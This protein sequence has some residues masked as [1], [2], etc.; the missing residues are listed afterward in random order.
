MLA[1]VGMCTVT[2]LYIA[3]A[4]APEC[5]ESLEPPIIAS[6]GL[7]PLPTHDGIGM[8]INLDKTTLSWVKPEFL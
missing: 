7:R 4:H 3:V 6:A 5:P 8:M 1:A 2:S